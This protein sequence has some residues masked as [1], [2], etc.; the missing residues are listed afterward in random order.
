MYIEPNEHE[1]SNIYDNMHHNISSSSNQIEFYPQI[2][3]DENE[4][5]ERRKF[6]KQLIA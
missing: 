5:T 6:S 3:T 1:V 4:Q 2:D